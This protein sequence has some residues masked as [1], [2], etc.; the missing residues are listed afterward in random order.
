MSEEAEEYLGRLRMVAAARQQLDAVVASADLSDEV[1]WALATVQQSLQDAT[2]ELPPS[3]EEL[4]LRESSSEQR[5]QVARRHGAS[6][7]ERE[8]AKLDRARALAEAEDH[9][10][11]G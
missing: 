5:A 7:E 9:A 4:T 10:P 8:R 11:Q 6:K 1:R 2:S 3:P